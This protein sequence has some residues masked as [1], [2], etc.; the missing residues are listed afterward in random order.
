[1]KFLHLGRTFDSTVWHVLANN[2][3]HREASNR[4]TRVTEGRRLIDC[5]FAW[6]I[7]PGQASS[8]AIKFCQRTNQ[9]ECPVLNK[10]NANCDR[11]MA[12]DTIDRRSLRTWRAAT[13]PDS[14]IQKKDYEAITIKDI[15]DQPMSVGSTFYAHYTSKDDLKRKG[16][17][18][19]RKSSSTGRDALA[20]AADE[21]TEVWAS[22]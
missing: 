13:R 9:S 17:D 15:C 14:L 4:T 21:G 10:L 19:L 6:T 16:F 7:C 20:T 22:A 12:K 8:L 5:F 1:M 18:K 3:F 11:K 2:G